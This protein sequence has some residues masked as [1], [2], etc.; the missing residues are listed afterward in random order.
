M[1]Q[2]PRAGVNS[3]KLDLASRIF[4]RIYANGGE[5][6]KME[7]MLHVGLTG[8]M[9]CGKSYTL[10]ELRRLGAH[11][12]ESDEIAHQVIEPGKPA[13]EK[14]LAHFGKDILRED[15]TIDRK[16]LGTI[17]FADA[18]ARQKLNQI[19]HPYVFEEEERLKATLAQDPGKLRSPVVVVDAALMIETGSYRKYPVLMVVY[20]HPAIQVQRLMRRDSISEE[21]AMRR[22]STQMPILEKVQYAD[23]V[24][25]NSGK[26]SE[27]QEQVKQVFAALLQRYE[28]SLGC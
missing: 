15:Q 23:Y 9:A 4:T 12:I 11:T 17:V 21:E 1:W 2:I 18:A 3:G 10:R 13:Y 7:G 8:G 27:T 24:I 14:I 26:L 19:V 22:I 5:E 16:K 6:Y 28:E 20:C 25:E